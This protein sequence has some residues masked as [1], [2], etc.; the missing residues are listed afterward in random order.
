MVKK[1]TA[2][3]ALALLRAGALGN[4]QNNEVDKARRLGSKGKGKISF[5]LRSCCC[6]SSSV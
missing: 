2:A 4:E 5:A 6:C 3:L 1:L